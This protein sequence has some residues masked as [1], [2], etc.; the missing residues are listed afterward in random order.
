MRFARI[1]QIFGFCL[2]VVSLLILLYVIWPARL[3]SREVSFTPQELSALLED[4]PPDSSSGY[5][6]QEARQL[7][8]EWPS[9][10]QAG[11]RQ[12]VRLALEA[13][14]SGEALDDMA[15]IFDDYDVL[16]ESRLEFPGVQAAPVGVFSQPMLEGRPVEFVWNVR[17]EAAGKTTGRVWL[18]LVFIPHSGE[19]LERQLLSVQEISLRAVGLH[20][21]SLA[22]AQVI[23]VV[24]MVIGAVLCLDAVVNKVKKFLLICVICG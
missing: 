6:F 21:L 23:G 10:L 5:G 8:L 12:E 19:N 11:G 20:G 2:F 24:G 3:E 18:H 4:M 1:R 14:S 15:N 16:V 9:R 13:Q 22:A 7:R 17:P